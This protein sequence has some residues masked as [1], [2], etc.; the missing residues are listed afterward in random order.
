MAPETGGDAA[1]S[2]D[3][4]YVTIQ[5]FPVFAAQR[6]TNGRV[7]SNSPRICGKEDHVVRG[8]TRK[9]QV[10]VRL[11]SKTTWVYRCGS[12]GEPQVFATAHHSIPL[13]SA[14]EGVPKDVRP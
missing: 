4:A 9:L 1:V 7:S 14:V 2:E 8:W 13:S 5:D 12:A 6:S 11:Q 3:L 10:S